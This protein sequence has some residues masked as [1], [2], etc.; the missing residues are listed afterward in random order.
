VSV[1]RQSARPQ[2]GRRWGATRWVKFWV[3]HVLPTIAA[4][5]LRDRREWMHYR[6]EC[7]RHD[8][9]LEEYYTDPRFYGTGR[10]KPPPVAPVCPPKRIYE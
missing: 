10:R 8:R 3:K 6:M 4:D 7:R 5:A 9:M 2:G 1:Y